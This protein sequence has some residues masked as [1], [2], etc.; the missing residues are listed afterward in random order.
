M[1]NYSIV[2]CWMFAARTA[3]WARRDGGGLLSVPGAFPFCNGF[4]LPRCGGCLR[5]CLPRPHRAPPFAPPVGP[6][7]RAGTFVTGA[8]WV[9]RMEAAKRHKPE[10][11]ITIGSPPPKYSSLR[12]CS[13]CWLGLVAEWVVWCG[14]WRFSRG[15][16]CGVAGL[17]LGLDVAS[18]CACD[19]SL[20]LLSDRS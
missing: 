5:G 8:Q 10:T 19:C 7:L 18:A 14:S 15:A 3:G 11:S 1:Y 17:G 13:A 6:R 4:L 2:L 9:E 20:C 12:P 16:C